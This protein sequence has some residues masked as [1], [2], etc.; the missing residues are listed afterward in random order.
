GITA[1]ISVA[2]TAS[3]D[4]A[5]EEPNFTP[6]TPDRPVPVMVTVSVASAPGG[7]ADRIVG[8]SSATKPHA[9]KWYGASAPPLNVRNVSAYARSVVRLNVRASRELL[10]ICTFG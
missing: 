7:V 1:V 4:V 8:A 6:V 9:L 2:D 10:S 5:F 3:K